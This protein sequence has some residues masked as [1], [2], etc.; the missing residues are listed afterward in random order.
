MESRLISVDLSMPIL[1]RKPEE[2]IYG[3]TSQ[4]AREI[5]LVAPRVAMEQ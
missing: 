4:I 1:V 5:H 2:G 3:E